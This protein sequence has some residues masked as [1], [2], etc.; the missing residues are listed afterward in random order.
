MIEIILVFVFRHSV[1][2]FV[3][4]TAQGGPDLIILIIFQSVVIQITRSARTRLW[5][6]VSVPNHPG[7]EEGGGI[8]LSS[9]V[10]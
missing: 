7:G 5:M 4:S 9:I 10:P 2:K 1:E 6:K 8:C 3:C